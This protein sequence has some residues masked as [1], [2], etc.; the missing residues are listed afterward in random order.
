MLLALLGAAGLVAGW[1]RGH[2]ASSG[3]QLVDVS[4]Q[5]GLVYRFKVPIYPPP[6][7]PIPAL[8]ILETVGNG[9]AFLD[10]DNDGNLD[11]LLVDAKPRLYRGDGQGHFTDVTADA[12][13]GKIAGHFL[14]CAVGDYDNDGRDDLYLSGYRTAALLHND[15]GRR[16]RDLTREAGIHPERWGTSCGFS[17]LDG[18]GLLDLFVANYVEFG[19]DP[20]RYLQ[21]CEPIACPPQDYNPELPTLYRNLGGERFRD[22]SETSGIHKAA[23][24]GLGVAFADF[25]DDGDQDIFVAN[26]TVA[27][28]L[29]RN[30]GAFHFTNIGVASGTAYGPNGGPQ[31]GMGVDWADF[32][33]DGRLDVAVT[34]FTDQPKSL[35]RNEGGALFANVTYASVLGKATKP[36]VA[37][38]VRWL[39]Y[40]NDGWPDLL[41]ANG[42]V[43]NKI[44]AIVPG[45]SYR[46]PVQAFRNREGHGFADESDRLGPALQQ[47]IV[48]RGLATGDFDNDGRVDALI[49]DDDGPVR[50]LHN[51]GGHVGS[52]I[53]LS[54]VGTGRSN[55]DAIGA[56]VVLEAGGRRQVREVQTAGSY[57]SAS[58]RRLH[59]GLGTA[60]AVTRI[61]VRWPD[62][63][64]ESFGP[65]SINRYHTLRQGSAPGAGG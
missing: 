56:R 47:P 64:T 37:F 28:D 11:V 14:G 39:D 42:N 19:P 60:A 36:N 23:G 61:T 45:R 55:R 59:F 6:G 4:A 51:Q 53:G 38:G 33:G 21:R 34:T 15:A 17:D 35:Y 46:Q 24:K 22:V 2:G 27:G 41:I 18:D 52:W 5:A 32:D 58:D 31:G 30:D 50:L 40:D 48:G 62:G 29:F 54:L 10:Y 13:L 44:A 25:D 20:A 65:L 9:C 43:D 49:I 26:D 16:F 8:G 1:N 7:E 3:V 57:L 63:S 12:G